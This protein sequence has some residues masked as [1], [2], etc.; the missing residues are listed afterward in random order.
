MSENLV[1]VEREDL[2]AVLEYLFKDEKEDYQGRP[3]NETGDHIFLNLQ[4]LSQQLK[5]QA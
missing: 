3:K 4:R 5:A 1:T 2:T